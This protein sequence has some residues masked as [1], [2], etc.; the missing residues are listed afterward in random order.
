M[1]SNNF[2]VP[3]PPT[4]VIDL[5]CST[6]SHP[7]LPVLPRS[8]PK[9]ER[10]ILPPAIE[11]KLLVPNVKL[12]VHSC[13]RPL[14]THASR[15]PS[16]VLFLLYSH[17]S[18]RLHATRSSRALKSSS[19]RLP[20]L[21]LIGHPR[22]LLVSLSSSSGTRRARSQDKQGHL[23]LVVDSTLFVHH[24]IEPLARLR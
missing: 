17:L 1:Y 3:P 23:L 15:A 8:P 16:Y 13:S 11:D 10:A 5:Q 6:R 7:S 14:G 24:Q 20:R 12:K 22:L 21:L 2:W 9:G 19:S 4:S 18:R